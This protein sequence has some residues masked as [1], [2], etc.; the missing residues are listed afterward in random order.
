ME[1]AKKPEVALITALLGTVSSFVFTYKTCKGLEKE[2]E[3]LDVKVRT[4]VKLVQDLNASLIKMTNLE[5]KIGN[6]TSK[7]GEMKDSHADLKEII[8]VQQETIGLLL[9]AAGVDRPAEKKP[10]KKLPPKKKKKI[11]SEDEASSEEEED[12]DEIELQKIRKKKK[13]SD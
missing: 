8:D 2:V 13:N 6:L 7:L 1:L 4:S 10:V 9:D 3:E 11:E 5:K 12:D